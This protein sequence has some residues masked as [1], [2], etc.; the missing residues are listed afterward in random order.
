MQVYLTGSYINIWR[1]KKKK[2]NLS[3]PLSW[4]GAQ[5]GIRIGNIYFRI[6]QAFVYKSSTSK[7]QW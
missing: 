5:V 3:S 4:A 1:L 2:K 6:S 7:D